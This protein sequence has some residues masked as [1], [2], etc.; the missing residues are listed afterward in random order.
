M[1]ELEKMV[2]SGEK[3]RVLVC[4]NRQHNA[5]YLPE[6]NVLR[7]KYDGHKGRVLSA[8]TGHGLCF[9]VKFPMGGEAY[10]DLEELSVL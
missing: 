6:G 8:H 5:T 7:E 1:D 3:P 4:L 2:R 10:Y 9:K